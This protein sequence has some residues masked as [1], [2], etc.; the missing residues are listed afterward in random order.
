MVTVGVEFFPAKAYSFIS[1][2]MRNRVKAFADKHIVIDDMLK[3]SN[4]QEGYMSEFSRKARTKGSKD[5]SLLYAF[6]PESM[7]PI[8]AKPYPGNMLD[9]TTINNFVEENKIERG[10]LIM[11]K[12]FYKQELSED[13]DKKEGLAYLIPL[14]QN[15]AFIKNY[16]M[17]NPTRHLVGYKD[18][19]IL[20]KKVKM[21]N[22]TWLYSYRD[23][24]MAYEQEV[25]YVQLAER[26]EKFSGEKYQEH[27]YD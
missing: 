1:E 16:E 12:G 22:G 26:K 11:D 5:M 8:A 4:S 21:A 27:F 19:T 10:L 23:P 17:D 20:Y 24:R 14:K 3:G 6:D 13:L 18:A 25:G 2:F 9:Q 7:E 15:S